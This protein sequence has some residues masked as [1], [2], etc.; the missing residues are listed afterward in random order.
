MRERGLAKE[1]I[2]LSTPAMIEQRRK[3]KKGGKCHED[4]CGIVTSGLGQEKKERPEDR[5]ERENAIFIFIAAP[6]RRRYSLDLPGRN[7]KGASSE[8]HLSK[9]GRKDLKRRRRKPILRAV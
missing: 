1:S 9:K 6:I 7:R 5:R 3:E 2:I 4:Q 8:G